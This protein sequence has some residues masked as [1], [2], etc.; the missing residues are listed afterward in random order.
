MDHSSCGSK[1]YNDLTVVLCLDGK[2]SA[3]CFVDNDAMFTETD[4]VVDSRLP[5]TGE[6]RF[7]LFCNML[8][9]PLTPFCTQLLTL[10]LLARV[11]VATFFVSHFLAAF[12]YVFSQNKALFGLSG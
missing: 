2:S 12:L 9:I 10:P 11:E 5:S 6:A 1:C 8:C 4:D 7:A 3:V